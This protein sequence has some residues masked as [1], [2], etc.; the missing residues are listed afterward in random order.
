M[1]EKSK[2]TEIKEM[3]KILV[4]KKIEKERENKTKEREISRLVSHTRFWYTCSWSPA[5]VPPPPHMGEVGA[6]ELQSIPRIN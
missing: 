6:M 4:D 5:I 2:K 1:R 3:Q